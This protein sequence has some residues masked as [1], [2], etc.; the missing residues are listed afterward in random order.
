MTLNQEFAIKTELELILYEYSNVIA[1]IVKKPACGENEALLEE[2]DEKTINNIIE[3]FISKKEFLWLTKQSKK[4]M[5]LYIWG[6]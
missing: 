3:F 4:Y 1:K 6:F 5:I 2:N